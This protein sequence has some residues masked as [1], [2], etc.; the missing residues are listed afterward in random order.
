MRL[1]HAQTQTPWLIS[2]SVVGLPKLGLGHDVGSLPGNAVPAILHPPYNREQRLHEIPNTCALHH[3]HS[4]ADRF[5]LTLG[6]REEVLHDASKELDDGVVGHP[7]PPHIIRQPRVAYLIPLVWIYDAAWTGKSTVSKQNVVGEVEAGEPV[8][9]ERSSE[10]EAP[11]VVLSLERPKHAK[12]APTYISN[13]EEDKCG[14]S[15]VAV[16]VV[17]LLINALVPLPLPC[18]GA[19]NR[20]HDPVYHS[21]DPLDAQAPP[22]AR[23][24]GGIVWGKLS[25]GN[26]KANACVVRKEVVSSIG[27]PV[28]RLCLW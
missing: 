4:K 2:M 1:L 16:V 17:P 5:E 21:C 22:L 3:L 18:S 25:G 19:G 24:L 8:G 27:P 10:V 15:F 6:A 23:S 13:S 20:N 9:V 14:D 7:P 26:G 11:V 28:D 12:Q